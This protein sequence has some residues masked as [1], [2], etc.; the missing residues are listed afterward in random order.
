MFTHSCLYTLVNTHH[1][2]QHHLHTIL[3][4]SFQM[5]PTRWQ[6]T[7]L[8]SFLFL[9]HHRTPPPFFPIQNRN[10]TSLFA[11][12]PTHTHV[13]TKDTHRDTEMHTPCGHA[14]FCLPVS[15]EKMTEG[16]RERRSAEGKGGEAERGRRIGTDGWREHML[17]FVSLCVWE[18]VITVKERD[19]KREK[20]GRIRNRLP[21]SFY[22][23]IWWW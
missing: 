4:D 2:H 14:F 10:V 17:C 8:L 7:S 21:L 5:H 15:N 23:V 12:P 3:C 22:V 6:E 20:S 9:C 1:S 19:R 13:H 16:R 18:T 11:C